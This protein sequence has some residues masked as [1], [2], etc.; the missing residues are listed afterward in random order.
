MHG[1]HQKQPTAEQLTELTEKQRR[2]QV[3]QIAFE[4]LKSKIRSGSTDQNHVMV[5]ESFFL[6][7]A[8]LQRCT[9]YLK[10]G[11]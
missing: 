2:Q 6:A 1:K 9:V 11:R 7:N 8:Y 10:D 3:C 4:I 5:H